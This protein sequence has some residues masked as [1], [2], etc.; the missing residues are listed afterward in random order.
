MSPDTFESVVW[1]A[2]EIAVALFVLPKIVKHRKNARAEV[3]IFLFILKAYSPS[4]KAL[5]LVPL[6]FPMQY[7]VP[8]ILYNAVNRNYHPH[9]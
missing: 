1:E 7:S 8:Y 2:E 4:F 3:R 9:L 5:C 6:G